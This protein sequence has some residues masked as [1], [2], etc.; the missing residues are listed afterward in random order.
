MINLIFYIIYTLLP[1]TIES[2]ITTLISSPSTGTI[3]NSSY[4]PSL[5]SSTASKFPL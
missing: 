4:I 1:S 3:T 5:S 2:A